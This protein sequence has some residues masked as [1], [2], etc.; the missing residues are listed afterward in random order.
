MVVRMMCQVASEAKGPHF[1]WDLKMLI[2][3]RMWLQ[4]RLN[5]ILVLR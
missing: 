5:G 1:G 3:R 4:G 2:G